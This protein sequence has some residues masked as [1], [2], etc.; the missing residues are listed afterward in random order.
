MND[1]AVRVLM[2]AP[3][4]FFS[5]RGCHVRIFEETKALQRLG[6]EVI[7]CTYGHGSDPPGMRI[8]RAPDVPWYRKFEPGPSLHKLYVDP[9]LLARAVAIGTRFR[10]HVIHAHLHEGALLGIILKRLF[11]VPLVLDYQGSFTEELADHGALRRGTLLHRLLLAAEGHLYQ[12]VDAI[13][14]NTHF[15]AVA[16]RSALRDRT[17]RVQV[18]P[19]GGDIEFLH[20]VNG[21]QAAKLRQSLGLRPDSKLVVY[22]GTLNR[23]EGIEVLLSAAKVLLSSREDV[24]FLVMGY[25]NVQVYETQAQRMGLSGHVK[26]TGRIPYHLAPAY[27]TLGDVAVSPKLSATEGNGKL[28]AYMGVGLP[29]VCFDLPV[30]REILGDLGVYAKE[31]DAQSLAAGLARILD[32]AAARQKLGR[33]LRERLEKEFSYAAIGQRLS[34]VYRTVAERAGSNAV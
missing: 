8:A 14:C 21:G 11:K 23:L 9:L 6:H 26:F 30:N 19:D 17:D 24:S 28:L 34:D 13:L 32:S 16:L 25:P 4:P 20:R 18:I 12:Y 33:A 1:P 2:L 10:P 7:V 29:T 5:D 15:A 31:G 3:T 22:L 27:L